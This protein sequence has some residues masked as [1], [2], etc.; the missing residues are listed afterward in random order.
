M[1]FPVEIHFGSFQLSLHVLL[2]TL[3]FMIG[4]RYFLYLRK[5]QAD[6]ISEKNRLWIIVGATFGAFFFSRLVGSLEDPVA[7]YHSEHPFIYFFANKTILGGL[8]GGLFMVELTKKIIGETSSSGDLFT[9]PLILA[10]IIGRV[11]CFGNGVYESTYGVETTFFTGMNLGDGLNRHPVALYE[12]GFL[13]FLWIGLI[14]LEKK[15]KLKSGY[16]FQIFMIAYLLFRFGIDFIKP[17]SKY[18][19]GIG[20]IQICCILGLIYYS[21]TIFKI[22]FTPS[23]IKASE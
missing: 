7:F 23:T 14:M 2:E 20:T 6:S 19:L 16:R 5:S 13:V 22:I 1:Q 15:L 4:F 21:N 12:I 17:G 3:A 10:M 9:F 8:L 11:G 18:L